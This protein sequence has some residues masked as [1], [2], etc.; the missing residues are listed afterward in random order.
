MNH[1]SFRIARLCR[2]FEGLTKGS[3]RDKDDIDAMR[4]L[5]RMNAYFYEARD[6]L[7]TKRT[8]SYRG[9]RL[10]G[11]LFKISFVLALSQFGAKV[12]EKRHDSPVCLR[13]SRSMLPGVASSRCTMADV[14][15]GKPKIRRDSPR[16]HVEN[17]SNFFFPL[18]T[19]TERQI[20][21][22]I[23]MRI[24]DRGYD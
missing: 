9:F 1:R 23:E 2:S 4:A 10:R 14:C 17:P 22:A 19:N 5:K 18:A 11:E 12:L 13:I 24:T 7:S 8:V 21:S 15:S 3:T 6:T 20:K 16:V